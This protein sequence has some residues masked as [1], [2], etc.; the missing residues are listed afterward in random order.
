MGNK[1]NLIAFGT[2]GNPNGFKQTFFTNN[3]ELARSIKTFDLNTNAIKLFP[4]SKLYSIRKENVLGS[5]I[6]SYSAYSHAKEQGSDRS[7]TF[8]G[9]GVIYTEGIPSEQST[10]NLLDEFHNYLVEHNVEKDVI[11]A[12]HSDNLSVCKPKGL[13]KIKDNLNQIGKLDFTQSGKSLVVYC[14]IKSDKLQ[15]FLKK[16]V[17]LL[18]KF[19]VI[20]FTDNKEIVEFVHQKGIY[21]VVQSDG[22]EQETKILSEEKR[23]YVE[24]VVLELQNE[25]GRIEEERKRLTGELKEYLENSQ[26]IH[27]Q[28]EKR[29][30]E[31]QQDLSVVNQSFVE[32]LNKIDSYINEVK[33]NK[34][35]SGVKKLFSQNKKILIESVNE[36]KKPILINS[37]QKPNI[38]SN[39]KDEKIIRDEVRSSERRAERR[40]EG[41]YELDIFKLISI[42]LFILWIATVAF[43]YL[44]KGK[45][46]SLAIDETSVPYN[47]DTV[48]EVNKSN[49]IVE[50]EPKPNIELNENDFLL[51]SKNIKSK[52]EAGK[53]I[54]VIFEKNPSQIGTIY[55]EQKN[56]YERLLIQLN[57]NCFEKRD[58]VY[59]YIKDT[60]KHIP[61]YKE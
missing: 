22:F 2:F 34:D 54:N 17:D 4:Q 13:E 45:E 12:S 33:D 21:K 7:G 26:R 5:G 48:Q 41:K 36:Q 27:T 1:V 59:Y 43:F 30:K 19:D 24:S 9:S 35:P 55:K 31:L 46:T 28:N 61:A 52:L 29:I 40:E 25:K 16:A 47:Q 20:Y 14:P 11:N 6:I 3:I 58:S 10:L 18:N 53:V 39:V 49:P 37:I 44:T 8:I 42:F 38:K 60:I 15:H 32:F 57:E 23:Q 51:V 56:S 50:L